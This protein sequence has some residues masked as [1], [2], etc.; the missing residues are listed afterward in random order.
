MRR[1]LGLLGLCWAGLALAQD[2][3]LRAVE[4]CRARLDSGADLGI[5]RVS[6]RCPELMPAIEKAPWRDLLPSTF[7]Q[8]KEEISAESLR[9]LSELLRH[10]GRAW[11]KTYQYRSIARRVLGSG[12]RM[13]IS[14]AANLGYRF[15]ANNLDKFYTC[16]WQLAPRT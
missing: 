6:R 3:A 5:D 8:R 9:V 2:P 14:V 13:T 11:K 10:T 4:E 16:D 15:Y 12:T 1:W 7:G